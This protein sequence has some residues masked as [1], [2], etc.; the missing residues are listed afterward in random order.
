[1]SI[2]Q[3]KSKQLEER[4][5]TFSV[6]I[7]KKLATHS[8][9]IELRSVI[10]QVTRSSTSIGANYHEA[11]N[12]SSPADFKNKIY[13]SKKES[14]ETEYW[15]EILSRLLPGEDFTDLKQE[16]RQLL[17]IFQKII[18]TMKAKNEK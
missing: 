15:L 8:R 5:I 7:I 9:K 13:I 6:A 3:E 16:V 10:D 4:T 1:M 18:S 12:A 14:A 2:P 11:N 17:M